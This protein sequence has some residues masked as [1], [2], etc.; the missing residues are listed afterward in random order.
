MDIKRTR[1]HKVTSQLLKIRDVDMAP[2]VSVNGEL[3]GGHQ[4]DTVTILLPTKNRAE[5]LRNTLTSVS[6]AMGEIKHEII[7]YADKE[8]KELLGC[9]KAFNIQKIYYDRDIFSETESFCWSKLMNHGFAQAS[10][11]WV[12]Y[13]SDDIVLYPGCVE[14]A[15][16]ALHGRDDDEIGGITFLHRNIF[17]TYNGFFEDFGYDTLNGDKPFINFGLIKAAAYK[18]TTGF[19]EK[20]RFFWADVD[21]CAQILSQGYSIIP[22]KNSL[23]DHCN[24]L[25]KKKKTERVALFEADTDY[26]YSKWHL[27]ALFHNK[28]PLE[29]VRYRH[30]KSEANKIIHSLIGSN[31]ETAEGP[32]K[33]KLKIVIDGVIFQLQRGKI[34]GI[35]RVWRN[36]IPELAR[37]IPNAE[38]TVLQ[39]GGYCIPIDEIKVHKV[40]AYHLCDSERLDKDDELL[41]RVCRDLKA[42]LFISTYF[43]RAPGV[44][45]VLMVHDL[46]PEKFGFDL[47][48]S[49]WVAKQRAVETVDAFICVSHTTRNDLVA[50]YPHIAKRPMIVA[51]NGLDACF[52]KTSDDEVVRIRRKLKLSGTYVML[53]GNRHG[54][55]NADGFIK[56]LA[57]MQESQ[58]PM[59]LCVGGERSLSSVEIDLKEKINIRYAGQL[60]DQDLIAAYGGASALMVPSQYEGFGLPVIEA[61]SCGCPVIA[62]GS[63]AVYEIGGDAVCYAQ[64]NSSKAI[65]KALTKLL[66]P[67][68]RQAMVQKGLCRAAAFNWK[69]TSRKIGRFINACVD[70]SSILLTAIVSTYNAAGFIRGCLEDLER[71]TIADRIE[72]IVIDSA[73][74]QDEVAVVRDFQRQYPN[75]KYIR[76]PVRETVYQA[77]NRGI[78]F[79][80]GKY[81][82]NANTDDRHRQDA[83]DQMV[84][85][86]EEDEKCALVYADIIRTRTA[87]ETFHQCT[88]TGMYRWYDWDRK[89]LLTRGCFIG[90][91]PVWRKKVHEA[92]GYFDESYVV[93]GDF[94]F[95]LRISQ[96]NKFCHISKPLG[97]YLEHANSIEHANEDKKRQEEMEI[98]ERYRQADGR[99]ILVG[100]IPDV[101]QP[102]V[103]D[104][105]PAGTSTTETKEMTQGGYDMNSPDTILKA[106]V[107][108]LN[109]GQRDA[110]YWTMGKLIADNPDNARLHSEMAVL[111]YE[112]E[113]VAT[114]LGHYKQAVALAPENT[115]YLKNLGDFYYVVL[116]QAEDALAQY[117]KVLEKDPN[118][119]EALILSGHVSISLHRYAKAQQYY[120]RVLQLDPSNNEVRGLLEK[121]SRS[122]ADP[123]SSAMSVDDLFNA[124]QSKIQYGDPAAAISLLEQLVLQDDTHAIAHNDLGV[125]SYDMGN[126]D[127]ALIHYQKAAALM[128][129]NETFQKNMADFYW[130]QKRDPQTALKY[131]IQALKLN[132]QDVEAQISCGQ[133]CLSVGQPGDAMDFFNAVLQ[134]EPWNEDA[135]QLISLAEQGATVAHCDLP[136]SGA[137]TNDSQNAILNLRQLLAASPENAEAHNDLG[138]LYFEAGDKNIAL[139]CYEQAVKLDPRNENYCKNLADFYLVEQ[140]RVEDAMKLY[141]RVLEDNPKD[142]EAL[143]ATGMVCSSIGKTEDAQHFYHR[144]LEIEPRNQSAQIALN[145]LNTMTETDHDNLTDTAVAG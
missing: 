74:E 91:Q 144:V 7:L 25:E 139:Q 121:I 37:Q 8:G 20:L 83:F 92:Y 31:E 48:Q 77:W 127:K 22:S 128:P 9:I 33:S 29:K 47:S 119:V 130:V 78:K 62:Y 82:S 27:T 15:L 10:G 66:S 16:L 116:K 103:A 55:K 124:A 4:Q 101:D 64:M 46:I 73:S 71:Q 96:T 80:T 68:H 109:D 86:L 58:K 125:L 12:M 76:T 56:A 118:S 111:A 6:G 65:S 79:A 107:H 93:A 81:V 141:L 34:Q 2:P 17:E 131:Y 21:I 134:V 30:G 102:H 129:E 41:R 145:D 132:P 43:T 53:V 1:K 99:N 115:F 112:Q 126:M 42:D 35:S 95:W 136:Q 54:Y 24:A 89:T 84:R 120:E 69:K 85:V 133:I 105:P 143:M 67:A 44:K 87:N 39:R 88:P 114:A 72:I 94:E 98:I 75:I 45:N 26:F 138:V 18:K 11:S 36:I 5:G 52:K 110:A 113:E 3:Y 97:L 59:V 70:P 50:L 14:N 49:E 51:H 135:Q 137:S 123:N 61:M 13:G 28:N 140:R 104:D 117:E 142:V 32:K 23:V 63:P 38:F 106:I 57:D 90:P 40:A 122:V 100:A 108:L 19:D 60:T